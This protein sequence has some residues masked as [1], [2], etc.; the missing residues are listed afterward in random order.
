MSSERVATARQWMDEFLVMSHPDLGRAGDV[1]PF[2]ARALRLDLVDL[3]PFDATAG[4]EEFA[5]LARELRDGL[6]KRAEGVGNLRMYLATVIVPHGLPDDAMR[7]MVE[8]V[9]IGLKAEF[10]ERGLMIGEFWPG[11]SGAGLHNVDFRPLAAPLPMLAMRHMVLTDLAFLSG[12]H[13]PDAEQVFYLGH[14]RRI[15]AA[16]LTG[17]WAAKLD[18]AE[19]G[20]GRAVAS[21]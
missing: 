10:V 1:C 19:E 16:Q 15:F 3:V 7:T 18:A 12:D 14:F 13:V 11:H 4:E 5:G 21:A 8:R 17:S 6:E 20:A 9:Q 2:M